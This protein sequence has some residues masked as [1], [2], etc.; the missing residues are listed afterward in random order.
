MCK[1]SSLRETGLSFKMEMCACAVVAFADV[2][3]VLPLG[4]RHE[5]LLTHD[6]FSLNILL[7]KIQK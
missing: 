1:N 5:D 6:S 7:V 3:M 2:S 4:Y